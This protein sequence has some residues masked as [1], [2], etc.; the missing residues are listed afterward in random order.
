MNSTP[1][2]VNGHCVGK[3]VNH[4]FLKVITGSKHMLRTPRAI[5]FSNTSLT[6]IE[7]AGAQS[8]SV[9]D[10][11]T[12]L[13]Y[14][15]TVTHFQRYSFDLK[16]GGNEPQ[17]ALPLENWDVTG[18]KVAHQVEKSKRG[19]RIPAPGED[20]EY[21]AALELPPLQLSFDIFR[22]QRG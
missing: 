14:S 3:V 2:F 5:A 19:K 4:Q 21:T 17:K 22:G 16:R 8:I 11:E 1:I 9:T 15:T 13:I 20:P 18:G 12:G 7:R 10:I 6:D